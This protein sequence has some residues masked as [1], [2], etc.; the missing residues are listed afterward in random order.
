MSVF[1]ARQRGA[2]LIIALV[3]LLIL[4]LLATHSMREATIQA[5]ISGNV[6]E[7]KVAGNAA[8][9]AL[10]EAE[11]RLAAYASLD[12]GSAYCATS[13]AS[14]AH[15]CILDQGDSFFAYASHVGTLEN[16]WEK[17][18]YA[19]DYSGT[20]ESSSFS[21]AP[22][23]N[24]AYYGYDPGNEVTNAEEAA[25]GVGPHYY[26]ATSAGQ[27]KGERITQVL[28]SVTVRRY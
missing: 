6:A 17:N 22:R 15:L 24:L 2:V 9:A 7:R 8:E 20:D 3:M 10:R 19:I 27:A 13:V 4:T 23:W 18:Q 5:R 25:Y 28:Q 26:V 14:H 16:W 11:R 1:P 12:E 21:P